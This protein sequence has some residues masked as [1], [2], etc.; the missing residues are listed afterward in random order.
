MAARLIEARDCTLILIDYQARLMPAIA[1]AAD[2]L[3][4][5]RRLIAGADLLGV[6][7]IVTEQNPAGIGPTVPEL[8]L[9]GRTTI[10]KVAFG[11]CAE[12]AF[13]DAI[14][15]TGDLVVAGCEAHVCVLQTVLGL[16]DLNRRVFVVADACGSRRDISKVTALARMAR[17]GAEIVTAEMV[18]FEWLRTSDHPQ[19]RAAVRVVK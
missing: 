6:R 2:V 11:A 8:G 14:G 4:E 1:G 19:F 9:A 3:V 13:L 5:A 12:P 15:T 16:L 7:V 18:M 10:E 17:H